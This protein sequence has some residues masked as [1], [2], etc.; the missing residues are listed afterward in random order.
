MKWI[1]YIS[2]VACVGCAQQ[3]VKD[4][5]SGK[6][7]SE[8]IAASFLARYPDAVP[9]NAGNPELRWNYEQG[10]M[11]V[12]FL[13]L[14]DATGNRMYADVVRKNLDL[15]VGDDGSIRTY[16]KSDYNLDMIA[17]G[18]ALLS[19][20]RTTG[21]PKYRAAA[22]TLRSQLREQPR[23]ASGGF[24]HKKVYPDQMWLDGIFMAEPFYTEYSVLTGDTAAFADIAHQILLLE[25]KARDSK[26]G[27]IYHG[28]DE[29][30]NQQWANPETGVSPNIW[31]RALGWYAMGILDVLDSF[32]ENHR[33]RKDLIAVFQRLSAA[34]INFQDPKTGLWHQVVDQ[35]GREG[36]YLEA[37][38][39]AMF[40]YALA[41]GVR[42]GYLDAK[43][44]AHARRAFN[45]ILTEFV[46]E[47]EQGLVDLHHVCAVAGLGGNPYRDGSYQYYVGEPRRTNDF[48]GVGPFLLAAMEIEKL[49]NRKEKSPPP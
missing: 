28:W 5:P 25:Q 9:Y 48:K 16:K 26:T 11:F 44:E 23:T 39:S 14:T 37:S 22:D 42:K 29:S 32:P 3:G 34:L 36:N 45:G 6:P 31:G 49:D 35:P 41:K 19:T 13:R 40:T 21:N 38:A 33:S 46:T 8:R 24:W 30:K 18:R 7:W 27:L 43:Y 17:S 15:Y 20:Y 47:N 1:A 4:A 2:L 12:G 10:L